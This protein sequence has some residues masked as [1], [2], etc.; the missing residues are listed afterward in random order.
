MLNDVAPDLITTIHAAIDSWHQKN[1]PEDLTKF[2]HQRLDK[3]KDEVL[4]KLMGFNSRWSGCWELDHCNGRSGNSIA[5]EY[6]KTVQ[7][8][9]I[10][11]FLADIAMPKLTPTQE[12]QLKSSFSAEYVRRLK[13]ELQRAASAR[14]TQ[15]AK[16]IIDALVPAPDI[17]SY[18]KLMSLIA[19]QK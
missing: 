19:D 15:D 14:A 3:S 7:L 11:T 16:A 1:T 17:D 8:K 2:I 12:K 18:I 5:G 4:L 13:D 10:Q 9:A 6:L